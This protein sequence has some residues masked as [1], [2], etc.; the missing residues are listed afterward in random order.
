MKMLALVLAI[1]TAAIPSVHAGSKKLGTWNIDVAASDFGT[2]PTPRSM[3]MTIFEDTPEATGYRVHRVD[4]DGSILDYEWR[5]T[6][7][8][9]PYRT[10]VT[11][12]KS[13]PGATAAIKEVGGVEIEHGIEPDGELENGRLSI[14]LDGQTLT[15][16]VSWTTF[17]GTE[18]KQKWVWRK[19]K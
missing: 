9:T 19:A 5:G 1:S 18:L 15:F 11:S 4:P 17:E 8:G 3:T 7:D 12:D 13:A 14:S 2:D 16:D 10:V 6:K